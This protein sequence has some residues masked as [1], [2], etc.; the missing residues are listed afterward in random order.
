MAAG[1]G[2][3]R[4]TKKI[5]LIITAALFLA[6]G[7]GRLAA[8]GVTLAW[9]PSPEEDVSGYKIYWGPASR[10]YGHSVSTGS[11]LE[12][13]FS[14]LTGMDITYAAVTALD[15]A[16]N[17]SGFSAEFVIDLTSQRSRFSLGDAYPNPFNPETAIPYYLPSEM[18]ID[19]RVYDV[20]GRLTAVLEKGPKPAG[21]YT[22]VWDGRQANGRQAANGAY[23]IR[24]KV[25]NF[26]LTK[27]VL[28]IK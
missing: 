12:Y 11:A 13:T 28:L 5:L 15:T 26:S 27:R 7:S 1:S 14:D 19:L 9:N 20:L 25:G 6:G 23:F 17:E 4:V 3:Q 10:R 16:G 18:E 2:T 8:Q 24:L 21:S 22:C